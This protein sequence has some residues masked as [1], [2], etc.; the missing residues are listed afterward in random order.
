M[1]QP[2][3]T[4]PNCGAPIEFQ[5]SSAVQTTCPYCQSILVRQDVDLKK[6]GQVADLPPEVSPI[7]L[8]TEGIYGNKSF[9]VVGR[10]IYQYEQGYWNEWHCVTHQGE[11]LWLSDAMAEYAVTSLVRPPNP[12][13][14]PEQVRPGQ[15]FSW[16]N[17]VYELTSVN[18]A[19]Y[20]GVQ[21]ELPFEYWDKSELVFADLRTESSKFATIDYSEQPPL[22]FLGEYV[23]FDTLRLKNLRELEGW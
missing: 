19:H 1:S 7:Q 17:E 11:S 5:F 16:H 12:L 15:K 22:L 4:C 8:L 13:P 21:G 18:H 6:V 2:K 20:L 23:E 9:R 3:S 10:I 14:G